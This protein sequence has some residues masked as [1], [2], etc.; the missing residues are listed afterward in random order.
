[1]GTLLLCMV[2]RAQSG[3]SHI[4]IRGCIVD[5][6]SGKAIVNTGISLRKG[7]NGPMLLYKSLGSD[8]CFNIN[9][10]IASPDSLALLVNHPA[11]ETVRI[12]FSNKINDETYLII[13]MHLQKHV[14]PGVSVISPPVWVRGDTTFFR[15]DHFRDLQDKKLKDMLVRMPDFEVDRNGNLLYKK[16]RIEKILIEGETLFADNVRML[17]NSIPVHA[18]QTVQALDNQN[19]NR[20]LKGL[21]GDNSV[22]LNISLKK[23]RFNT[24]FGDLEAGAGTTNIYQLTPTLFTL[25]KAVKIGFAGNNNNTGTGFDWSEEKDIMAENSWKIVQGMMNERTIEYINN[26]PG[27]RYVLN[28]RWNNH[29]EANYKLGP[30]IKTTTRIEQLNDRQQQ[31][32]W[33]QSNLITEN[34]FLVRREQRLNR[35]HPDYWKITQQADWIISTKQALKTSLQY[36]RYS[37]NALQNASFEEQATAYNYI[38][39]LQ[40]LTGFWQLDAE[41][42]HRTAYNR[43]WRTYLKTGTGHIRQQS[44]AESAAWSEVFNSPGMGYDQLLLHMKQQIRNGQAGVEFIRRNNKPTWQHGIHCYIE[45]RKLD[46]E[47]MLTEKGN[48]SNSYLR[49]EFS[50]TGRFLQVMLFARSTISKPVGEQLLNVQFEYGWAQVHLR[51]NYRPV[52]NGFPVAEFKTSLKSPLSA[53]LYQLIQTSIG[54]K[55]FDWYLQPTVFFP[56]SPQSFYSNRNTGTPYQWADI[57][58]S[59]FKKIGRLQRHYLSTIHFSSSIRLQ[60]RSMA[61]SNMVNKILSISIDSLISKPSFNWFSST[62]YSLKLPDKTFDFDCSLLYSYT[63]GYNLQASH[64]IPFSFHW[65][66]AYAGIRKKWNNWYSMELQLFQSLF[67]NLPGGQLSSSYKKNNLAGKVIANQQF[68]LLRNHVFRLIAEAYNN[69]QVSGDSKKYLFVNAEWQFRFPKKPW[70]ISLLVNNISGESRYFYFTNTPLRQ[71]YFSIPLIRR[72]A[73]LSIRYE[74]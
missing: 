28:R 53:K 44:Q 67:I 43:A 63:K 49:P 68:Q 10:T 56:S 59:L 66:H 40:N 61:G 31:S 35:Q 21:S 33:F 1:M 4:R 7:L 8:T 34:G 23:Q 5:D 74:L 69:T 17:I 11:Y 39:Q 37:M 64:L 20:L 51:E 3:I 29:F 38:S 14:L 62:G 9:I 60:G 30:S 15:A 46:G 54:Q 2:V 48:E 45:N 42:T 16:R 12:P 32:S 25:N 27:R 13:R 65:W 19:H 36:Y 24:R 57:S 6:S 70:S 58:Y 22:F 50:N 47:T 73:F 41:Y 52:T 71:D 72:N 26:F 55:P 18:I